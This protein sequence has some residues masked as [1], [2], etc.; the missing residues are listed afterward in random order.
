[1]DA[2]AERLDKR[3]QQAAATRAPSAIPQQLQSSEQRLFLE[4]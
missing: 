1:M 2:D 3:A 4:L